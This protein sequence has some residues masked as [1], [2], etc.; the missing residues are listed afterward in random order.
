MHM[1][2]N[3]ASALLVAGVAGCD[4]AAAA[5]ALANT[6]RSPM[7]MAIHQVDGRTII[8]DTYNASPASMRAALDAMAAIP[9]SRRVAVL[10]E[11]AEIEHSDSQHRGVAHHADALGIDLVAYGTGLYGAQRADDPAA[12][13]ELVKALPEGSVVLF[14]ASRVVGL[15]R[16][17]QAL[18][19]SN[20]GV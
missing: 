8:D 3:A 2:S 5:A 16:V 14:K 7:R 6:V 1:A 15:D 9:G 20:M 13:I 4:L 17:V 19:A 18:L 12:V 10:G 11:M